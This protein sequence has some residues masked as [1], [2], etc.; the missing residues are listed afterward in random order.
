ME[1]LCIGALSLEDDSCEM[2]KECDSLS[3]A[4]DTPPQQ[5]LSFHQHTKLKTTLFS[6]SRNHSANT[7]ALSN[8]LSKLISGMHKTS[9]NL[10]ISRLP[11]APVF[12]STLSLLLSGNLTCCSLLS[13][14]AH[15]MENSFQVFWKN[16]T[17]RRA[18][19]LLTITYG[20][21]HVGNNSRN[22]CI[23]SCRGF[24][25]LFLIYLHW[26]RQDLSMMIWRAH[27]Q[28]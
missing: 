1:S 22:A 17:V 4:I 10:S 21:Y 15:P 9:I 14:G 19:L 20:R 13:Y 7:A 18:M 28:A 8:H 25:N 11:S 2:T 12:T 6:Q 16:S 24:T 3:H 26:P 5:G 27:L 23:C